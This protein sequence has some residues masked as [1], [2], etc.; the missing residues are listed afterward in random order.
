M[1]ELL[2]RIDQGLEPLRKKVE[3]HIFEEGMKALERNLDTASVSCFLSLKC[4]F[5]EST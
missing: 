5:K 4:E 1:Y 3:R 2:A